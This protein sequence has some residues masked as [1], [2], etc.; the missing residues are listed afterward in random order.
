VIVT[1]ARDQVLPRAIGDGQGERQPQ[2][3]LRVIETIAEELAKLA[4]PVPD[5]LCVHEQVVGDQL[6]APVV[7]QPGAQC[8]LEPASHVRP[9]VRQGC[10]RGSPQVAEGLRVRAQDQLDKPLVGVDRLTL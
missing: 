4:H 8:P 6:A 10:Q 2:D 5:G 3:A 1:D 7:K 9:D